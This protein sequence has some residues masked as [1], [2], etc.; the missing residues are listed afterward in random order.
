M[1]FRPVTI[2]AAAAALFVL[3]GCSEE[4]QERAGAAAE[5]A[6]A[7]TAA[8]AEVVGEV[9]EGG[10]IDAAEGI[11]QGAGNLASDLRAGDKKEPGP[12]PVTGDDL[13]PPE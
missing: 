8:N 5:G 12:A 7:D 11:S 4:T 10:A 13:P 1:N 3:Q 6:A 9:L 2:A